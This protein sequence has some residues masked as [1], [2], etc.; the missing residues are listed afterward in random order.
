MTSKLLYS[1][2][3]LAMLVASPCRAANGDAP[4]LDASGFG[5]FRICMP[6]AA[7]NAQLQHKIVPTRPELRANP[8]CQYVPVR[9]FPGVAFVFVD[10]RL[11]RID[12]ATPAYRSVDA[13]KVGDRQDAAM[14]RLKDAKREPLDH[15]PEGVVLVRA[16]DAA[17][18]AIGYQFH[19]GRLRRMVAGDKR[20]IRYAEGCE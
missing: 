10:D 6:L 1:T 16:T 12:V 8:V 20:V 18:T 5:Q 7:V 4:T 9:D 14:R 13:V 17:P 11:Q 15:V 3:V 2:A 19:D